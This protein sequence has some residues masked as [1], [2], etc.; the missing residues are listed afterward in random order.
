M[1]VTF[2]T[3]LPPLVTGLP[4]T[5]V[6]KAGAHWLTV[7]VHLLVI[8][9]ASFEPFQPNGYADTRSVR[10]QVGTVLLDLTAGTAQGST[11]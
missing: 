3:F 10:D 4:F 7:A 5:A 6:H 11:P 2:K 9:H 8:Q 1:M